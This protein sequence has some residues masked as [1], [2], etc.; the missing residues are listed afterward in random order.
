MDPMRV[1]VVGAGN[2]GCAISSDLT[3]AGHKVKLLKTSHVL[4]DDNFELIKQ[5]GGVRTVGGPR[6]GFARLE[7]ITRDAA[8]ALADAEVVLIITQSVAHPTLAKTLSPHLREGQIVLLC[9]GYAGSLLFARETAAA[10]IVF[11]EGE[12]L[13]LDSRIGPIGEVHVCSENVR[14]PIGFFPSEGK[15]RH[16]QTIRRLYA[17]Y[18]LRE[19]VIDS[20]M[21]N[22]NLVVHT[23]GA[24]M[25]VGRI[26]HSKGEFWMYREAFTPSIWNL[27]HALDAEKL[28]VLRALGLP[29]IAFAE[30]FHYRT[31]E[32]L[33]ADS[34]VAFRHYAAEGSPKGPADAKTRYITEDVPMGLCLLVSLGELCGVATPVARALIDIASAIHQTDYRSQ[35][36]TLENLGL[37]GLSLE[38]LKHFL[39]TGRKDG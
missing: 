22:P 6:E 5:R 1:T 37:G 29:E 12:S 14:N 16:L 28:G 39:R 21:H 32:D 19:N 10:G 25:S 27:V 15:H 20:A 2:G 26:E 38:Q 30:S 36:R 35:G 24:I 7:C 34:M 33:S 11:G 3:L 18:Q 8:E 23:I 31:Y 4:H 13:P 9:P 17:N